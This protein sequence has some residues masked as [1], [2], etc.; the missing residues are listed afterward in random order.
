[1]VVVCGCAVA[2]WAACCGCVGLCCYNLILAAGLFAGV[3][4]CGLVI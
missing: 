2:A 4:C 1:M 3:C